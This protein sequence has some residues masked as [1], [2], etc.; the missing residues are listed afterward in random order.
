MA[1]ID[2]MQA[3]GLDA[4]PRRRNGRAMTIRTPLI[5]AL[6]AAAALAGCNQ[7]SHTIGGGAEADDATAATNARITLPP[8]VTAT[9]TYRCSDNRVVWVDWLSDNLSANI[10]VEENATSTQVTTAEVGKPMTA[11]GGFELS[12]KAD[13]ASVRIAVPGHA[14]QSCKA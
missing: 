12:G 11:P 13:A 5:I 1:G 8:S 7:E 4:W 10:R 9:K 6:A 3:S 2:N 14:S